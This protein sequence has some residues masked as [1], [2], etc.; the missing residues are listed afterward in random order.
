M[1]REDLAFHTGHFGKQREA[2]RQLSTKETFNEIFRSNHW[3]SKRSISGPGSEDE[4]TRE[5]RKQIPRLVDEL[6][7]KKFLDIPCGDF[8]WFSKMKISLDHYVGGDIIEAIIAKN[9]EVYGRH[10]VEFLAIDLIRDALPQADILFCR[11]CFV[12]LSFQ[13]IFRA[14]ENIKRSSIKYLLTTTF[15]EC[16]KNLEIVTGDW[17]VINLEKAPFNLP[18]PIRLINEKCTEGAGSYADKSLALWRISEL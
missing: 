6:A 14:L 11:D 1:K 15:S 10:N 17:R 2:G 3:N 5:I 18:K 9:Q 4:Q 13:D 12:H 16:D 7:I 8:R